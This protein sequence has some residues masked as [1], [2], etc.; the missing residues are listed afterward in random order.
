MT[1]SI[2]K[3]SIMRLS[4][5][6]LT[7]MTLSKMKLSIIKFNVITLCITATTLGIRCFTLG[8]MLDADCS[9]KDHNA[10]YCNA[11]CN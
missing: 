8:D 3:L 7:E 4:I 1:H 2:M 5:I 10:E 11:E 9:K 6:T